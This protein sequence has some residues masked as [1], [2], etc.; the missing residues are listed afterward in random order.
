MLL[1]C[2]IAWADMLQYCGMPDGMMKKPL[3][4][5]WVEG[6]GSLLEVNMARAENWRLTNRQNVLLY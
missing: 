2:C 4:F 3:T 6:A 1:F 5:Q